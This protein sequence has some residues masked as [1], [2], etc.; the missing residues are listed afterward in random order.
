MEQAVLL[1]SQSEQV[2]LIAHNMLDK[3][4]QPEWRRGL[5]WTVQERGWER[6]LPWNMER[7]ALPNA[8]GLNLECDVWAAHES[9]LS[10]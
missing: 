1:L 8:A 9:I 7:S 6:D 4:A 2:Q 3:I 10:L 5:Y